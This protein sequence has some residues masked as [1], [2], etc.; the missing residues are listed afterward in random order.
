MHII[1]F[2]DEVLYTSDPIVQVGRDDILE[3]KQAALNNPRRRIRLC[4]HRDTGARLHEMLIVHTRD[5]YVRPHKHLNKSESFHVVEG[6]ADIIVFD[7]TGNV[8]TV[9]P[10]G[11]YASGRKFFYRLSDPCFHTLLITSEFFVFHETTGGP[12][13]RTDS[14]FAPWAPEDADHAAAE[15]FMRAT[16]DKRDRYLSQHPG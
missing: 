4:G 5:T 6:L 8:S 3:L 16:M 15:R 11:D 13:V 12:F 10:M 1:K 9:V 7:D 2:N 14:I